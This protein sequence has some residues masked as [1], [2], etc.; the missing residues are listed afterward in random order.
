MKTPDTITNTQ[1]EPALKEP[2]GTR[3]PDGTSPAVGKTFDK[4]PNDLSGDFKVKNVQK[5]PGDYQKSF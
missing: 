1:D 3:W 4:S 2:V 5:G